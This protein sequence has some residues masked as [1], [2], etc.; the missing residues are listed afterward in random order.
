MRLFEIF[1]DGGGGGTTT[2][3]D[4]GFHSATNYGNLDLR[5]KIQICAENQILRGKNQNLLLSRK[6]ALRNGN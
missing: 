5:G 3:F 6:K 2:V 4:I 1:Q